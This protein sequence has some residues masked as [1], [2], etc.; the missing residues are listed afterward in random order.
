MDGVIPIQIL[1]NQIDTSELV[2]K[3]HYIVL[4]CK[5]YETEFTILHCKIRV[6]W[7]LLS[8]LDTSVKANFLSK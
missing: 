3:Q 4:F 7:L 8:K 6:T 1:S 2:I 5:Q